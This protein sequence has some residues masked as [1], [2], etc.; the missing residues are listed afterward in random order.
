MWMRAMVGVVVL[1]ACARTTP[2]IVFK[3]GETRGRLQKNGLRFVVMPDATTQLLEVDVRYEVGSREDPP[4]KAGLAHLVEHLMFL[5][6]PDGPGTPTL[7]QALQQATLGVNAYTNWDSTHYLTS[8]RAELMDSLVKIEA[9]R[10]Q[11]GCTTISEEEFL[12]EREVVRNE[13]RTRSRSPEDRIPQLAL[14]KI[15][16]AD[17]AYARMIGGD[18]EQIASIT[19][20]DACEFMRKYYVPERAIVIVA[21]GI[22]L[23]AAI[24]SIE[25]WFN[26]L[27]RREPAPRRVVAR[28]P[29]H[30]E[31]STIELD[32]ERPWVTVAWPLPDVRTPEGEAAQ[33]G[34]WRAFITAASKGDEYECA[35]QGFPT[36]LGGREAPAFLIA[37]E[38]KSMSK[39]DECLDFVFKAARDAGRGWDRGQWAQ[40]E[41]LRHRRQAA[42]IA[43]LE[44]LF[45]RANQVGDLVQ[46]TSDLDFDSHDL[47]V[48]HALEKIGKMDLE[49]VGTSLARALDPDRARVVVF[50]PSK[51]GGHGEHRSR[52]T[53]Q[54]QSHDEREIGEVDPAEAGRPLH[55]GVD[56][57]GVAGA[58]RFTLGNG[59]RVVLLPIEAMPVIAAELVFDGGEASSPGNPA[60]AWAAANFLSFPPDATI[61]GE[62]GIQMA[63]DTTADHTVCRARGMAIYTDVVIKAFERLVKVGDY[64]Q[65]DVE[66]WQRAMHASYKLKRAQQQLEF[67]RQQLVASYGPDHPYTRTGVMLPGS[68]DK[69]G[70]DA[71]YSFRNAHYTAANATLV[72]AGAFDAKRAA[73]RIRD[74]F[75]GFRS[76]SKQ[77]AAP[78]VAARASN[79]RYV[80]VIGSEDSQVDLA[81]LYPSA[82]GISGQQAARLILTAMLDDRIGVVRTKLGATYGTYARRDARV[83][84]SVYKLGGAVDS[85]RAGE[86]LRAMREG[87]DELRAGSDF[88]VAFVRARRRVLQHLLGES[89]VSTELADELATI[90]RYNLDP[91][92]YTTL[93]KQVEVVSPA[94]VSALIARELD[95][96]TEVVVALGDRAAL[97]KAFTDAGLTSVTFVEPAYR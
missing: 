52:V 64:S 83:A 54:T 23:R 49:R 32:L 31:R 24:A 34:V 27:D 25:R 71:M 37:L 43:S 73:D 97:T 67:E 82:P 40:I 47:Y 87:V 51:D 3:Y 96:A 7:M 59:M 12:R 6:R 19:L 53:F 13:I 85:A 22:E 2:Q 81:I 94:Q 33:V 29:A 55:L 39:L 18:D 44:P 46:F 1:A 93:L 80:G 9:I 76:G 90:T 60:L 61:L 62:T 4:G 45:A 41:E 17:H 10:M 20:A 68:I 74:V 58:T 84:G 78:P 65:L 92:Y 77:P 14:A 26:I 11:G 72:I 21:G 88:N 50:K 16:P 38:L 89:T 91:S 56:L 66:R 86:G 28:V 75:G 42:F 95:P 79:P 5:Q 36:I 63:C 30:K 8:A 15:Y 35:T 48:F 69:V 57:K 70:R